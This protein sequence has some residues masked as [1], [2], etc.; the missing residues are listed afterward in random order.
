MTLLVLLFSQ[1]L[2][3]FWL[4]RIFL[5]VFFFYLFYSC[6]IT[7]FSHRSQRCISLYNGFVLNF[8]SV[9]V[10][11]K[12]QIGSCIRFCISLLSSTVFST[13][14]SNLVSVKS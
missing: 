6:R 12:F 7:Y 9:L 11:L 13:R 3:N 10:S 14:V 4:S 2:S 5:F 1:L 8:V